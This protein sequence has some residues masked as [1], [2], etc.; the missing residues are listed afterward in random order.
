MR[1]DVLGAGFG[2]TERAD[3]AAGVPS[4]AA[5]VAVLHPVCVEARRRVG[6]QDA[7]ASPRR[8][9]CR[10]AGIPVA[11]GVF[12]SRQDQPYGVQGVRGLERRVLLLVDDVVGWSDEDPEFRA[13][14]V[15]V[16]ADAG[17]GQEFGQRSAPDSGMSFGCTTVNDADSMPTRC[18][19]G[20]EGGPMY[21]PNYEAQDAY[22]AFQ[23][24]TR[25]LAGDNAHAA[26]IALERARALEPAEGSVREALAR[27]YFRAGRFTAAEAE[28]QAAVDIDPVND[29][30]HYGIGVCRLRQGDVTR[31][32]RASAHRDRDAARQR[33]L[34]A[35][36]RRS[37]GRR[38]IER[39]RGI[40]RVR[41]VIIC[42]DLDGVI[43]RGD[44]VIPGSAAGVARL[45]ESGLRVVFLTNNSSGTVEDYVA[46]L[47]GV[48]VDAAPADV[49]S[50]AQAAAVLLGESLAPGA[51]VL[52]CAGAGV[53][54]AMTAAG[55][56][57]VD[58][59]PADAVVVGWHREFDFERLTGAFDA[60]RAGARFVATNV[61]PTYPVAGGLMPG[62]GAL[63]AA[64]ATAAGRQ[65]EVAGKPEPATVAL[66]RQ[67]FGHG[68]VVVGDRPST[69][70]ALRLRWAGRS[71]WCCRASPAA[72]A[73]NRF[74]IR[75]RRS[76]QPISGR[77]R[78]RSSRR[79]RT[80][81]RCPCPQ[82]R[83][84]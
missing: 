83:S 46:R 41:R 12:V 10:G 25:L 23:E 55:F 21:E 36:A 27:A 30:A 7:F 69:D 52:A 42:C 43:W 18:R 68:G 28:F 16:V 48:G 4:P 15:T 17:K 79:T 71:R 14:R 58:R 61:D 54:Q 63:V 13:G 73:R 60:V 1:E 40:G 22:V 53:V 70:G 57:V 24:G 82:N 38:D 34:P 39:R 81:D 75:R 64:V 65:P 11:F 47:R 29:Y 49:G 56:E 32:S 66:V 72:T 9:Q 2:Q 77:S 45:Q 44:T 8:E 80:P 62:A 67:R 74:R 84:G 20:R 5:I 76:S 19:F 6:H 3:D 26:V 51:R 35:R 33:R 78:R 37:G 50:S 59:A 31:G